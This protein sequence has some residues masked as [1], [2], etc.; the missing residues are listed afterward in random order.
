ML[1]TCATG[2]VEN[3]MHLTRNRL[4]FAELS[5]A[6]LFGSTAFAA[7]GPPVAAV[8]PVTD[9]YYGTTVVDPYRYFEDLKDPE[10]QSWMK[11]QSEYTRAVLDRIPG[12][13]ALARRIH[14]LS[15]SRTD[16]RGIVLRGNR[17]FYQ[18]VEPGAEQPKLMVRDGLSGQERVLVDPAAFGARS[19]SH[20]ALDYYQPSWD[21]RLV[22][23]GLSTGGSE[24]STMHVLDV[25]SGKDLV[26]RIERTNS[27]IVSW[28]PDGRSFFYMKFNAVKADTPSNQTAFNARA[29]LHVV[30]RNPD[31]EADVAV[32]GRGVS[33]ATSVPEGQGT[34]VLG[35]A[36]SPYV[37]A[38]ANHNL[39]EAPST[40]YVA[41]LAKVAGPATP[42][43]RFAD[44]ADGV[45]QVELHGDM[46][47]ALSL[48]DA[49]RF[50]ILATPLARPDIRHPKVIVPEGA[51]VITGFA[52]AKDG[53][54]YRERLG[55][56]TRL[57]KTGFDGSGTQAVS[58]PYEGNLFGP[59]TEPA[60]P[61]A[62]FNMQSWSHPPQ[63]FAYDPAT[64]TVSDTGLVPPSSVDASQVE[65]TEVLVTSY[66]GTR[67]P[68]S[69]VHRKGL[70]LDG[71]HPT[72]LDGYGAYG[73]VSES[74][75][76]PQGLAW[77][78]RGGVLATAHIRGGGEY[79]ED[80]HRAGMKKTK[81][82]TVFDFIACG[83]YLVDHQYTAPSRM[84]AEGGS[85]G[86]ITVGGAMTW[87]PDLFAVILD[88]VGM[89]DALR[90][91][92]E[93]NGPPNTVEYGSTKTEDGFHDLYAMGAYQHIANGTP[94][95]AVMFLTGANDPRVA[96]WQMMKMA[97][98]TQAATSSGKPVLLRI[99]YDA[100]HGIGSN[101]SQREQV[102]ADTWAFALWQMGDPAFQPSKP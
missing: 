8:R 82:N 2:P 45:S 26:E 4:R 89:S 79:G 15:N 92:T 66:D 18:L 60:R 59:V 81:L 62:L 61:G 74:Y 90:F 39:D 13:E 80:W 36:S 77:I 42:W 25:A 12:R 87:R 23:Y 5:L 55:A 38:V 102:R 27:A 11:G 72:I 47:Y 10:V 43:I 31:G 94:Y 19:G 3:T 9:T 40:L 101:R 28:R 32:F 68:L 34:Y 91:E 1:D 49:S 76:S 75:F 70:V 54:Y 30:G 97:A 86:G 24:A 57:M 93:P 95:P 29:Y 65:S 35:S 37:V 64:G 41:P 16:R 6:C 14:E 98:R 20:Y 50:R 58:L 7:D 69:I 100:G 73:V 85:A 78:E 84:A 21:G 48:K 22:A 67:V 46:L 52:L 53:L 63:L 71:T 33:Q 17:L 99:D 83:Q 44:V 56:V 96:S 88:H 51:G